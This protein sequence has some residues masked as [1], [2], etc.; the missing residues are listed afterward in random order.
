VRLREARVA[1][2]A[3]GIKFDCDSFKN[4][5]GDSLLPEISSSLL[6]GTAL[7]SMLLNCI[8][9]SYNKRSI[10]LRCSLRSGN[11]LNTSIYILGFESIEMHHHSHSILHLL[12][13]TN[14]LPALLQQ[15]YK[16][17]ENVMR[18][19]LLLQADKSLGIHTKELLCRAVEA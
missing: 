15:V 1:L 11:G 3:K 18:V 5:A 12:T 13:A 6:K 14:Q 8:A 4:S 19:I 2:D 10:S 9:V 17:V 16:L 7:T